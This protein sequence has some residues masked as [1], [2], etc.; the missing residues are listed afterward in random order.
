[1]N[2]LTIWN[3]EHDLFD[4]SFTGMYRNLFEF[5]QSHP[6]KKAMLL[7][8]KPPQIEWQYRDRLQSRSSPNDQENKTTSSGKSFRLRTISCC[9]ASPGTGKTSVMIRKLVY[10]IFNNTTENIL[11]L[12]YTNRAVDEI[13]E[14]IDA[15]STQMRQHYFRIG[16]RYSSG[17]KWQEQLLNLKIENITTRQD[18]KAL[19]DNH[20][21]VVGT[22]SS[23]V[24]KTELFKLKKFD[25]VIIDEASQIPEPMLVG[26]LPKLKK[27][28]LVGDHRQLPA[29]VAQ[30]EPSSEV[31]D[32]DLRDIGLTNM[33]N[34]LFER[35][36]LLCI[37]NGWD[38][39]FAQLSHQGRMHQEIMAFP[40]E[41]FYGGSLNILPENIGQAKKQ[42]APLQ[43]K[44]YSKD[45]LES[46][47][48]SKRTVFIPTPVDGTSNINK[49]NSYEASLAAEIAAKFKKAFEA[50][51]N[52]TT[53][54]IGIITPY[55]AQI[56]LIKQALGQLNIEEGL[57]TVDTVERY[58]GGARQVIIIS[59]CV[60]ELNQMQTLVS[61]SSEGVDRKL[62]VAMTRAREH[63][64][65]LGNE[66]LL[67]KND[68][69]NQ[70]IERFSRP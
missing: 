54:S 69:Y 66:P 3:I 59:L 61:L 27:F 65:M 53:D 5:A 31:W 7:G 42:M 52:L 33:R 10:H 35:L 62:N 56:A 39:A 20:R 34:S 44:D 49:T 22:V 4:S 68:L 45:K 70:M 47:I 9:G 36:Y 19:I 60:N 16:S 18:L 46:L 14:A 23:V 13:C 8:Q 28:I 50:E 12:A 1:L 43:F 2:N 11:L 57:I 29:V 41:F 25:Q 32:K 30:T 24:G 64:I 17:E 26:I 6:D 55:R 38:H 63:L 58:Q 51:N 67:R 15:I 48:F 37:K 40:N 21:I